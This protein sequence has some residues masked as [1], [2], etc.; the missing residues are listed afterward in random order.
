MKNQPKWKEEWDRL[1]GD[2][3][4]LAIK[5]WDTYQSFTTSGVPAHWIKAYTNAPYDAPMSLFESGLLERL[6]LFRGRLGHNIPTNLDLIMSGCGIIATDRPHVGHALVTLL[7]HSGY[8]G[9]TSGSRARLIPTNEQDMVSKK[10][11]VK[12][13]IEY[14]N[15]IDVEQKKTDVSEQ[16]KPTPESLPA[17][18][19]SGEPAERLA[20]ILFKLLDQPRDQVQNAGSWEHQVSALLKDRQSEEEIAAVMEFAVKQNDYS[21]EYLTLAKDPMASF[22]K[23]YDNLHKRWK[24]LQ[25]GAAAAANKAAKLNAGTKTAPGA[26]GNF[27]GMEF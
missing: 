8:A 22:V 15:S 23:N 17:Q 24:A 11:I 12:K 21:A 10:S 16:E 1:V 25:K 27:S 2:N 14:N 13:R 18:G 5:N 9:D 4:Y 7:T 26:H 6:R 20:K 19:V 3:K